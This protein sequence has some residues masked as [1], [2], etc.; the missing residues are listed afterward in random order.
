MSHYTPLAEVLH[1]IQSHNL[2]IPVIIK[3]LLLGGHHVLQEDL[4]RNTAVV[5]E[6][7]YE[8]QPDLVFSWG[9]ELVSRRLE[10][11]LLTLTHQQHG[12]H[13]NVKHATATSLDGS[14]MQFVAQ[15]M[16]GLSPQLWRLIQNLLDARRDSRRSRGLDREQSENQAIVRLGRQAEGGRLQELGEVGLEDE[17]VEMD[18]G[19]QGNQNVSGE[20]VPKPQQ[21]GRTSAVM[22]NNTLMVIVRVN[23]V[24]YKPIRLI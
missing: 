14:F 22:R 18:E 20:K 21:K 10:T 19:N 2:T 12:F 13:F 7:L 11:E 9:F 5:L 1:I 15:K 6:V 23:F 8:H 16:K 4:I 17:D 24:S 3:S